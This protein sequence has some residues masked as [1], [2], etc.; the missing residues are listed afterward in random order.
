MGNSQRLRSD[1]A[2][3]HPA[4]DP[5][6]KLDVHTLSGI[7]HQHVGSASDPPQKSDVHTLS[8]NEHQHGGSASDPPQK[9][10]VPPEEASVSTIKRRKQ[11][12][13]K[14]LH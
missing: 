10:D 12:L 8:G 13:W 9:L 6:Q 4:S 2:P 1:L 5:P 11:R 14:I 7:E 3:V